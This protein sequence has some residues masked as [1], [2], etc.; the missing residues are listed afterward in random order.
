MLKAEAGRF[1]NIIASVDRTAGSGRI[2]YVNPVSVATS[3]D[4]GAA[5]GPTQP[6]PF[7]VF[8]LSIQDAT[9][10]ELR[11]V[12]P[13]IQIAACDEGSPTT[14]LVNQD[15]PWEPG[16]QR[17]VLMHKGVE[18]ARFEGGRPLAG[19]AAGSAGMAPM[20]VSPSDVTK[21][22]RLSLRT[23]VRIDAEEGVTY[24]I[25]V[26]PQ[27]KMA[28]Q[29]IAVGRPTPSL[30]VDR[31]QFPGVVNA[32]VRVLRTT[33]FEDEVVVEQDIDMDK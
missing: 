21:P 17:I 28:W 30:D 33:G 10:R 24:T 14:A 7:D 3:A 8:E 23:P 13:N 4:T 2:L 12:Q 16:M 11:R 15:L 25:Q 18:V 29:T 19:V 20:V 22:H 27:G 9:G 32:T 6:T 31:N 1:V 5:G 26:R